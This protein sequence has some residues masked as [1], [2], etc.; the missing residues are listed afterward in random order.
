MEEKKAPSLKI[1]IILSFGIQLITYLVPL[2]SAPYVARILLPDG[3]GSFSYAYSITTI[4]A[5]LITWGFPYFGTRNISK[6]RDD[7]NALSNEF[8]SVFFSRALF[9]FGLASIFFILYFTHTLGNVVDDVLLLICSLSLL[10]AMFDISYLYQ[11]LEQF[12]WTSLATFISSL[13]YL[14]CIFIF[15][16]TKQDLWIY[17]LIKSLQ[18]T[19][20]NIVLFCCI[21]GKINKPD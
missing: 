19:I 16:R 14:I 2:I 10:N 18:A 8:W 11:G 12:K 7:K 17:T 21:K 13:S 20:L 3:V 1:N 6:L 4:F 15:V 9:F 5:L